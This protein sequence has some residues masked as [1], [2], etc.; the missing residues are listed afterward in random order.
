MK[1]PIEIS[2]RHVH[3][4]PRDV[5]KLFGRGKRLTSQTPISQTGQFLSRERVTLRTTNSE[6]ANVGIVGPER[7]ETQVE[8]AATDARRLGVAAPV[9]E[10]GHLTGTPGITITGPKGSVKITHG[11]ILSKRHIHASKK[12]A[13]RHG[14]RHGQLVSVSIKGERAVTFHN[15]IVRVHES[16]HW[17]LHLDTDEANAAG[18][19][20][21]E[22]GDVIV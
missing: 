7:R 21:N 11:V 12:D 1:I 8:L 4:C 17:R 10:S 3:L 5:E 20:G 18:L 14:L 19:T 16:F 6:F 2:A 22:K 9:R 15:V 13:K